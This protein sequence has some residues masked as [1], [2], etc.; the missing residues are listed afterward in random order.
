MDIR[1]RNLTVSE[2]RQLALSE[3]IDADVTAMKE[4]SITPNQLLF[5]KFIWRNRY[6]AMMTYIDGNISDKPKNIT[7]EEITELFEKGI[8][9]DD[10]SSFDLY[11]D[12]LE[13]SKVA[14][15]RLS[16]IYGFSEQDSEAL[17]VKNKR[18]YEMA[19]E[20][21]ES[22]PKIGSH[23]DR[24]YIAR[25]VSSGFEYQ[26]R[27]YSDREDLFR[28][29]LREIDYDEELHQEIIK[30]IKHPNFAQQPEKVRV[31]WRFVKDRMWESL[32][33]LDNNWI[34]FDN[35]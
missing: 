20:F 12:M 22:Y 10:W 16:E 18:Y 29:Y 13:I 35:E 24:Q 17:K 33:T 34:Q 27:H 8:F 14:N 9:K 5:I 23:N 21:W 31:I 30:K 28:M 25:T 2:I 26:G 11:P 1:E 7:R 15:A 32:D 3:N 19:E 4:Y 6:R